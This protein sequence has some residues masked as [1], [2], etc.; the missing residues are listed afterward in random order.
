[1]VTCTLC[2]SKAEYVGLSTV[3]GCVN[4]S[5]SSNQFKSSKTDLSLSIDIKEEYNKTLETYRFAK[6]KWDNTG[7]L[8]GL[9]ELQAMKLARILENQKI[10]MIAS[11]AEG[12]SFEFMEKLIPEILV[13]TYKMHFENNIVDIQPMTHPYSLIF[14]EEVNQND[15]G[16]IKTEIK[17]RSLPACTRRLKTRPVLDA[18]P[19][20]TNITQEQFE[21]EVI[22]VVAEQLHLE[23]RYEIL[24]DIVNLSERITCTENNEFHQAIQTTLTKEINGQKPDFIVTSPEIGS[25]LEQE[26]IPVRI[27]VEPFFYRNVALI[28]CRGEKDSMPRG[29][30]FCPYT[31]LLVTPTFYDPATFHVDKR[32]MTRSAKQMFDKRLYTSVVLKNASF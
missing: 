3:E 28:G 26:N 22:K 17:M 9:S 13:K 30:V 21:T 20:M 2:G 4:A 18:V 29:Y 8:A 11:K 7:L 19:P 16:D 31:S 25:L 1:M 32:F 6:S 23:Q 27:I 5:C 14:Y 15:F 12:N 24:A 10:H